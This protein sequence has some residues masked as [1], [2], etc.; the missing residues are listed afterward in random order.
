MHQARDEA[1]PDWIGRVSH[2]DGN[3]G[4]CPLQRWQG[5]RHSGNKDIDLQPHEFLCNLGK[6]LVLALYGAPFDHEI[7]SFNVAEF[8]HALH[9]R[10]LTTG[11]SPTPYCAEKPDAPDL[12]PLLRA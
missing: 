2:D 3:C 6:S 4:S 11:S 1:V 7:L 5:G 9:E 12:S 8:A 10:G